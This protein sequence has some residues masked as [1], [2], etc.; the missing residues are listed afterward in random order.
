MEELYNQ[1]VN[2]F[3]KKPFHYIVIEECNEKEYYK[4][5]VDITHFYNNLIFRY[6][7]KYNILTYAFVKKNII[8][9]SFYGIN[10]AKELYSLLDSA[11]R[12]IGYN[13]E[14][15]ILRKCKLI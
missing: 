10:S 3:Y 12:P 8:D 6:S 14:F 11:L 5:I 9:P 13:G 7:R 15:E 1:L 2:Y 4:L